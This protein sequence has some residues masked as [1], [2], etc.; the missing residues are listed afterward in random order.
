MTH[1]DS[2]RTE[3]ADRIRSRAQSLHQQVTTWRR[4]L[5]QHPELAFEEHQTAAFVA[6]NLKQLGLS[7]LTG[8]AKTGITAEIKGKR[9]GPTLALRADMDALPIQEENETEYKSRN[10][11]CMH[12]CGHDAHTSSLLGTAAILCEMREEMAG[13]IRLVF[14]PSEEKLPGGA[15]VMLAE[16]AL[17]GVQSIVGQHVMPILDVGKIGIRSGRYMASADELYFT[18]KGRGGHGAQPH[19]VIDPVVIA[20]HLILA[21]QQVVSRKADPRLPSVLSIGTVQAL[22]ATNIIPEVVRMEGTFRTFDES[23]RAQAHGHIR[24]IA[25]GIVEGM[26]GTVDVDIRRGY[27]V[28]NNDPA[29]TEQVRSDIVAFIGEENVVDLDLW[30]A[31]EDFAYYTQQMPGCFYRLG[32]RNEARGIVHGLHTPRFDIDEAALGHSTGL[33]AF[34]ALQGLEA[35]AV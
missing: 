26:G 19:T 31:S 28:L 35:Q 21:L 4:H 14:Q 22:G 29:L 30:M 17:Q 16:G 11:G 10:L 2:N 32:T 23:W 15:S 1:S 6:E 5:H 18:V 7:P 3:R 27:P 20:S 12:A 13:T 33:M 25:H 8:I 24:S 34:L 9:P